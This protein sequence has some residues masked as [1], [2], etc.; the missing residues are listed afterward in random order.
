MEV[1]SVDA[2]TCM[3][4]YIMYML[5]I[6]HRSE[7][8]TPSSRCALHTRTHQIEHSCGVSGELG[9]LCEGWVSPDDDLV[10]GVAVGAD[11]LVGTLGPRQVAHLRTDTT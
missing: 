10:L 8:S 3:Y 1:F 9:H 5:W 4:M 2:C 6:F 7:D 11:Q